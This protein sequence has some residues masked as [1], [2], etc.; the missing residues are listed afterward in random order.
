MKRT[1]LKEEVKVYTMDLC[2]KAG[3]EHCPG[4]TTLTA[5][6]LKFGPVACICECHKVPS[7]RPSSKDHRSV[8]PGPLTCPGR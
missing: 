4:F 6:K 7:P 1:Q 3:H 8:H 2:E 5:G